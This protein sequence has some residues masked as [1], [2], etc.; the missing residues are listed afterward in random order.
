MK[1]EETIQAIQ[2]HLDAIKN[3]L[4]D[5]PEWKSENI[6]GWISMIADELDKPDQKDLPGAIGFPG[7]IR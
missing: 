4:N 2:K 1:K 7:G 6:E 5:F 3:L